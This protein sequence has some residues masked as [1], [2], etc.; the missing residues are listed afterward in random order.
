[1]PALAEHDDEFT[2]Y[3][4]AWASRSARTRRM[5]L[6]DS[7]SGRGRREE[8]VAVAARALFTEG[9]LRQVTFRMLAREAQRVLRRGWTRARARGRLRRIRNVFTFPIEDTGIERAVQSAFTAR[10]RLSA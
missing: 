5:I 8:V 4:A 6:P 1:M 10:E 2:S 7:P 9:Q 3:D